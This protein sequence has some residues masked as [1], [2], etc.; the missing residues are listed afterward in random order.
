L[1]RSFPAFGS[2]RT[3][4]RQSLSNKTIT[5]PFPQT[6]ATSNSV[7]NPSEHQCIVSFHEL[8]D[9]GIL[10][11]QLVVSDEVPPR[12]VQP[13]ALEVATIAHRP[14]SALAEEH[15]GCVRL[16]EVA[17]E[18]RREV[19]ISS[20]SNKDHSFSSCVMRRMNDVACIPTGMVSALGS[21]T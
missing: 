7:S 20:V 3:G 16:R 2:Y 4:K 8:K 11:L 19:L 17:L 12:C 6:L 13:L 21:R 18:A 14:R 10:D 1:A 9:A 15:D 5:G